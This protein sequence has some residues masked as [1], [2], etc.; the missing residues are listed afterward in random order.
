MTRRLEGK[1]ALVTGG[2]RGIGRAI[3][4]TFARE[5]ATVIAGDQ[6]ECPADWDGAITFRK[7]D[8]TQESDWNDGI[9]AIK[10]AHGRLD[11]LVNNAGVV[12]TYDRMHQVSIA[13]YETV[14]AVIQTGTFLGV[15]SA[16]PLMIEGG[17]GAIVNI[18]STL[19][20]VAADGAAPYHIAKAALRGITKNAA[21]S[22]ARKGIRVNSVHPGIVATPMTDDQ[23]DVNDWTLSMTPMRRF[24]QPQEIAAACLFLAS[25]EASYITGAELPVDGGYI[26]Q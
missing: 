15:R 17:G 21:V 3:C 1:I 22:Y 4:Q 20:M 7:L 19:G 5:G 9:A 25:D 2:A 14:V 13:D 18:S 12:I 16:V 24:A 8:V 26:A 23:G 10:A 11:I 6:I